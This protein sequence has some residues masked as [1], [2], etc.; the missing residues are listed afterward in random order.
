[1]FHR[2]WSR[3]RHP[4]DNDQEEAVDRQERRVIAPSVA[5]FGGR[6]PE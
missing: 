4:K 3:K 2:V 5:T 6:D 1:M